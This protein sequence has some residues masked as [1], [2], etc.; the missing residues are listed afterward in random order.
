MAPDD[1]SSGDELMRFGV[2]QGIKKVLP[3]ALGAG[4][5]VLGMLLVGIIAAVA[6]L[7]LLAGIGAGSSN[8]FGAH[9]PAMATPASRPAEWLPTVTPYELGLPNAVVLAVIAQASGGAAYEDRYYCSNGQSAGGAC[10]QAYPGTHT[11]GIGTG[12][13][14]INSPSGLIPTRQN[15]HRV[16]G[17]IQ[18]GTTA[19]RHDLLTAK[20]WQPALQAFHRAVQTPPGWHDPPHYADTIQHWLGTYQIV[21]TNGKPGPREHIQRGVYDSGPHLG[22][23]ALAPWS[24]QSGQFQDPGNQPEWVLAVGVA[25]TG[26]RWSHVW[27]PHTTQVI[28]PPPHSTQKPTVQMTR[29]YVYGHTLTRPVSVIGILANGHH[30]SFGW[31]GNESTIPMWPGGGAFGAKVPLTGSRALVQIQATWANGVRDTL[32]WPEGAG[33]VQ[34]PGSVNRGIP[35]PPTQGIKQWWQDILLASQ[36]TGVPADWIAAEM[37]NE[38]GGNASAANSGG[39]YGLMQ[40][41]ARTASGLPGFTPGARH[42][43]QDNLILGAELLAENHRQWHSWRLA[44][45]AYYGGSGGLQTSGVH[46]GM[47]WSQASPLL[48]RIP[49]PSAGNSLTMT[50]YANHIE[51]TSKAVAAMGNK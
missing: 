10:S 4:L 40:L 8:L 23:W 14:G 26:P 15:P 32:N 21:T 42:N 30:V 28:P 16:A 48:D 50:A 1:R 18:T 47:P 51:A 45:A 2:Q 19:L 44:S 5:P 17:N 27:K 35:V 29:Y 11:R 37:L 46:P 7:S 24:P 25:P 36:K 13:M 9:P 34:S 33:S 3:W 38:S 20:Y 49:A 39:A 12:L 6:A 43:P 22:A 41:L 31:S